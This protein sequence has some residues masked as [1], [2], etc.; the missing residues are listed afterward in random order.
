MPILYSFFQKTEAEWILPNIVWDQYIPNT[1]IKQ[2]HYK[3]YRQMSLMNI[4]G[5]FLNQILANQIQQYRK[6]IM[7]HKAMLFI[8]GIQG[9][10]NIW[11]SI[12]VVHHINKVKKKNHMII[13]IYAEKA[14]DKI[15][16]FMMKTLAKLLQTLGKEDKL[17]KES[18]QEVVRNLMLSH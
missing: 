6:R 1:K 9:W 16:I 10:F 18:L 13:L 5:K 7:H 4:Y 11:K 3:N 2:R 14:F 17:D 8:P 12:H 15:Y